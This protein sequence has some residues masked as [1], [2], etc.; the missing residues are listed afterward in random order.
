MA[1]KFIITRRGVF[2]LGDVRMHK[3]LL[4]PTDECYGGGFYEFDYTNNRLLLSGAS[5][6]FGT[7]RWSWLLTDGTS[8]KIPKEY[9]GMSIAYH[10]DDPTVDDLQ[11]TAEF[12]LE[13]V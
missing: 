6:D 1:K 13:Y 9:R 12:N 3:D 4:E 2:R 5:Y 10:Y 11:V 7:P 8:L